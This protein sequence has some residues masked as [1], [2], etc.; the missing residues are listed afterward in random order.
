M[1]SITP[2]ELQ[3][4]KEHAGDTKVPNIIATVITCGCIS[5]VAVALR[6]Y[7][8]NTA[9]FGI[10]LDDFGILI[11]LVFFTS[12]FVM[13][14]LVTRWGLGR[15]AIMITNAE[16]FGK[17]NVTNE[18]TYT[19][20]LAFVKFSILLF[21]DRIFPN[22]GLRK[23]FLATALFIIAW[24]ITSIFGSI[25]ACVPVNKQWDPAVPGKC[26]AFGSFVLGISIINII[27]DFTL[28]IL[29]MPVIWGLNMKRTKKILTILTLVAGSFACIVS[30]VRL[31]SVQAVGSTT[32]PSW[33]DVGGGILSCVEVCVG[34]VAAS[35]PTYRPLLN[36][37][38]KNRD[39]GYHPRSDGIVQ[40]TDIQM[41][42]APRSAHRD[43]DDDTPYGHSIPKSFGGKISP[44]SSD[45][46]RL[47]TK[48]S[49]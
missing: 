35:L 5:Y 2:A 10:G 32:D 16:A 6:L 22:K 30:I 23:A 14:A 18:I 4:M 12:Y 33:D 3:H 25:F 19:M 43:D 44:A 38:I 26:M 36:R 31:A 7:A 17:T 24:I 45:K 46:E 29:P 49:E 21:Y 41:H 11:A 34:I 37:F 9:K 48:L 40:T 1:T 47:Y 13:L 20:S 15:H 28:L 42:S 27:T 39:Y 8:R